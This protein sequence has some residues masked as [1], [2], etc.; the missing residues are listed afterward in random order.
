MISWPVF[1][2]VACSKIR[3]LNFATVRDIWIAI[4]RNVPESIASPCV[5]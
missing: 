3:Q 2:L 5:F 4:L 1:S